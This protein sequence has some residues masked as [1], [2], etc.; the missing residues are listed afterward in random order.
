MARF[1]VLLLALFAGCQ[2]TQLK[3]QKALRTRTQ[4]ERRFWPLDQLKASLFAAKPTTPRA[5]VKKEVAKATPTLQSVKDS[6]IL[7]GSFGQKTEALCRGATR[8]EYQKCREIAGNRLFCTLLRRQS[9]KFEGLDGV[10]EETERCS[11][12]DIMENPLEATRDE[13]LQQEANKA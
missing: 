12:V 8:E 7:S 11:T 10:K 4:D 2:A 3:N 6:V 13:Q 9:K 5:H 1:A